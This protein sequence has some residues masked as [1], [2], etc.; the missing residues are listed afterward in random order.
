MSSNPQ[1]DDQLYRL[2][3]GGEPGPVDGLDERAQRIYRRQVRRSLL[4]GVRLA[5]PI[6]C[7]LVPEEVERL[8][9]RWLAEAPPTTRIY[10]QLP[11]EFAA[12]LRDVDGLSH[13]A[14]A[15][16]VHWE[17]VEVDVR[18]AP[19]AEAMERGGLA[20]HPS[21][22]LGIYQ[23]PVYRMDEAT[24]E[25]P[26]PL[27]QPA[28]VLAYRRDETVYW[29]V[30]EPALAQTLARL[31]EG[32]LLDDALACVGELYAELDCDALL[33]DLRMLV[34]EGALLQP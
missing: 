24:T 19:E 25:W 28:F 1:L 33:G 34:D 6:A 5:I 29:R 32:D 18:N 8:L 4:G 10:W 17:S 21:A 26:E 30:I 27:A 3:F 20:L 14:L 7:S 13:P 9:S 2:L 15:D 12:W 11:L 22:R 31:A 23:Y 16:L